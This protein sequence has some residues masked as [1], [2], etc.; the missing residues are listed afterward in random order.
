MIEPACIDKGPFYTAIYR[1]CTKLRMKLHPTAECGTG[2]A[3][4]FFFSF[5]FS[6][7]TR[8]QDGGMCTEECLD[9]RLEHPAWVFKKAVLHRGLCVRFF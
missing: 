4:L 3:H 8:P 7:P 6:A 9:V 2:T 1:F 5:Y